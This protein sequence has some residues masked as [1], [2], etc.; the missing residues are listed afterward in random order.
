MTGKN[1]GPVKA[2]WEGWWGNQKG[3]KKEYKAMSPEE[4][5]RLKDSSQEGVTVVGPTYFGLRIL[6]KRVAFLLDCSESMNDPHKPRAPAPEDDKD[7]GKTVVKKPGEKAAKKPAGPTRLD[8]AKKELKGALDAFVR[9]DAAAAWRVI[10]MDDD[11]DRRMEQAFR[12]LLSHMMEDPRTISRALRVTFVAK[13]FER[14]GDQATNI[15][16]QI[17]DMAE[18]R[19]IKHR[20][21]ADGPE[22]PR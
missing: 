21:V 15:C 1:F 18:A 20:I 5:A 9:R 4:L 2:Q 16:E 11:L 7:R 14:I 22:D 6:S 8:V 17:V 12:V 19:V 10:R 3:V 13:Y